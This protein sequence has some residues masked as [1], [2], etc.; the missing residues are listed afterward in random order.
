[1]NL[2]L[3]NGG[4]A[5]NTT[6]RVCQGPR[7]VDRFEGEKPERLTKKARIVG[8]DLPYTA[9]IERVAGAKQPRK[10]RGTTV[11]SPEPRNSGGWREG[12]YTNTSVVGTKTDNV[13]TLRERKKRKR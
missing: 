11:L 4:G 12:Y 10:R 6:R 3:S 8:G 13:P 5:E 2:T 7:L 9:R 1:L